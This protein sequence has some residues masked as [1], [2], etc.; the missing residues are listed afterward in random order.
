MQ[1]YCVGAVASVRFDQSQRTARAALGVFEDQRRGYEQKPLSKQPV[2]IPQRFEQNFGILSEP[3]LYTAEESRRRPDRRLRG[4]PGQSGF[5]V[6][7]PS[8]RPPDPDRRKSLQAGPLYGIPLESC[9]RD[10]Q[11][12][13]HSGRKSALRSSAPS[14][15]RWR[16]SRFFGSASARFRERVLSQHHNA[17]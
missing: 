7:N 12:A 17:S 3:N 9:V 6:H 4:F 8:S 14:R 16:C 1:K 13:S 2:Q 11:G 10:N 15:R 5:R